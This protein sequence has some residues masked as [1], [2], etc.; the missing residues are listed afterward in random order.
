MKIFSFQLAPIKLGSQQWACP[1]C[2]KMMKSPAQIKR[3][4]RS[5]T[6]EK[7]YS[8]TF[9]TF[10]AVTKGNLNQHIRSMHSET[11]WKYRWHDLSKLT[12]KFAIDRSNISFQNSPIRL[13]KNQFA[14]PC[15]SKIMGS[16]GD[17]RRHILTHTGEKP[18][19]CTLCHISFT[20]NGSLKRH[21]NTVHR[22]LH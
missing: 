4:V 8:C 12:C 16:A 3:H 17:V 22:Y 13:G 1:I 9:C 5:H 18:F 10:A 11:Y 2:S 14:C 21:M 7:P 20:A 15:C 19:S 6:G